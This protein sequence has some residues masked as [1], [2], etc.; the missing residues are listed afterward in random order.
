MNVLPVAQAVF[1]GGLVTPTVQRERNCNVSRFGPGVYDIEWPNG[2]V[3]VDSKDISISWHVDGTSNYAVKFVNVSDR[4]VRATIF[5]I[6]G[7][8]LTDSFFLTVLIHR[9]LGA[10]A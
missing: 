8:A 2:P 3:G 1:T 9:V 4:K 5:D 10:G 7:N 6:P